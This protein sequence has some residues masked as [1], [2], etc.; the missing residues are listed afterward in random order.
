LPRPRRAE[1]NNSPPNGARNF[2]ASARSEAATLDADIRGRAGPEFLLVL[3][4]KAD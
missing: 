3:K 1:S 4:K 2:S